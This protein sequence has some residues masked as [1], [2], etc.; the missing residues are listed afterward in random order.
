MNYSLQLSF[1]S[2]LDSSRRQGKSQVHLSV[3]QRQLWGS[4]SI[5]SSGN[6]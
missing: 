4:I 1:A 2:Q 3:V 6:Y 5:Y